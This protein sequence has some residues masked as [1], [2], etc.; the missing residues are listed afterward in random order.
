MG[1]ICFSLCLLHCLTW[2]HFEL[3]LEAHSQRDVIVEP[4]GSAHWARQ[5]ELWIGFFFL[6]M[7]YIIIKK[8]ESYLISPNGKCV[9]QKLIDMTSW[10]YCISY[11]AFNLKYHKKILYY[12]LS[13]FASRALNWNSVLVEAS[14]SS[15]GN[16]INPFL[17]HPMPC[18]CFFLTQSFL[19]GNV[20]IF[21]Q[22]AKLVYFFQ[23]GQGGTQAQWHIFVE[24]VIMKG[25]LWGPSH[26]TVHP[27]TR[28]SAGAQAFSGDAGKMA[29]V[30][31][32]L[33]E[34][35]NRPVQKDFV[36]KFSCR[37]LMFGAISVSPRNV[38]C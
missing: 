5:I 24:N 34:G 10:G 14:I 38:G 15:P 6:L 28:L 3:L 9:N 13:E 33:T 29:S 1:V 7:F 35:T 27:G 31:C 37:A 32:W 16:L 36:V 11:A 22:P 19:V 25:E 12:L 26:F 23:A 8:I 4:G 30:V 2:M 21:P 17:L 18:K 20:N